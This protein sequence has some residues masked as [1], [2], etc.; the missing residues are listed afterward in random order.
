MPWQGCVQLWPNDI[1]PS[2]LILHYADLLHQH[3][4]VQ[5][6]NQNGLYQ[7]TYFVELQLLN[8]LNAPVVHLLHRSLSGF[9]FINH[10]MLGVFLHHLFA[11]FSDK[12][13]MLNFFVFKLSMFEF[14]LV[15][16]FMLDLFVEQ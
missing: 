13:F 11:V 1:G 3:Q 7:H 6:H 2:Q 14:L 16:R 9:N 8:F 10:S 5:L 15:D 12:H 4:I